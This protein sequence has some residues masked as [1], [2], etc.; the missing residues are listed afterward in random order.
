MLLNTNFKDK[1]IE[2]K[3]SKPKYNLY[4]IS[5]LI[6]GLSIYVCV[7]KKR[8]SNI[9]GYSIKISLK[10]KNNITENKTI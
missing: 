4:H 7:N 5:R 1:I 10:L 6:C 8:K 2:F 3:S 9:E